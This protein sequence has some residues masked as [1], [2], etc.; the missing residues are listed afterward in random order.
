MVTPDLKTGDYATYKGREIVISGVSG[1]SIDGQFTDNDEPVVIPPAEYQEIKKVKQ[2]SFS[3]TPSELETNILQ[4]AL[5]NDKKTSIT[6]EDIGFNSVKGSESELTGSDK[7]SQYDQLKA[8]YDKPPEFHPPMKSIK[9]NYKGKGC[10]YYILGFIAIV[11]IIMFLVPKRS[12]KELELK[13]KRKIEFEALMKNMVDKYRPCIYLQDSSWNHYTIDYQT[14]Y[15][16]TNNNVI[17]CEN[18]FLDDIYKNG[19]RYHITGEYFTNKM[20]A[21]VFDFE[22]TQE[23]ANTFSNLNF[24][25]YPNTI[26]VVKIYTVNKVDEEMKLH[27]RLIDY[28]LFKI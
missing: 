26:F 28:I 8:K 16:D 10:F 4:N 18:I 9:K 11:L 13:E 17:L 22:C 7:S 6:D 23:Q 27:G 20:N 25:D 5:N 19:S 12:D 15:A 21:F 2:D 3:V 24:F 1:T 14:T